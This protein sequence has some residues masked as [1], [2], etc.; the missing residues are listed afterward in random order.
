MVGSTGVWVRSLA[1]DL[2]DLLDA[3]VLGDQQCEGV[4]E[5]VGRREEGV[6]VGACGEVTGVAA[7]RCV[8]GVAISDC[9][10]VDDHKKLVV[11]ERCRWWPTPLDGITWYGTVEFDEVLYDVVYRTSP[12][13][14]NDVVTH[15]A[16]TWQVFNHGEAGLVVA[17]GFVT[18]YDASAVPL[19]AGFDTGT[20]HMKNSTWMGNGPVLTASGPFAMWEGRQSHTWGD[21]DFAALTGVGTL[22]LN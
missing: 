12:R 7:L 9:C 11:G 13:V 21:I 6:A 10:F 2:V 18:G 19:M 1:P 4:P 22:R 14:G 15:W 3:V 5:L 16:E 17:N 8:A 20:T